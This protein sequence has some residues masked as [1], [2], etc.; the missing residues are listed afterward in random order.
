MR[1]LTVSDLVRAGDNYIFDSSRRA[2]VSVMLFGAGHLGE[3]SEDNIRQGHEFY[4]Y[5]Y[6]DG[7]DVDVLTSIDELRELKK[8]LKKPY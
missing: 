8:V 3:L 7:Q 2:S 5:T 4:P 6:G 1:A